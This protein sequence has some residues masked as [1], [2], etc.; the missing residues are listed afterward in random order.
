MW[1]TANIFRAVVLIVVLGIVP[2]CAKDGIVIVK[3]IS[4]TKVENREFKDE[5]LRL[6]VSTK[7][8]CHWTHLI[9]SSSGTIRHIWYRNSRRVDDIPLKIEQGRFRTWSCKENL[10][11][12]QWEVDTLDERGN[13]LSQSV[14]DMLDR[15]KFEDFM[16]SCEAYFYCN[17]LEKS[18]LNRPV[19][20]LDVSPKDRTQTHLG[21]EISTNI[22]EITDQSGNVLWSKPAPV[23]QPWHG[24]CDPLRNGFGAQGYI[25][26]P[27]DH[28]VK[29]VNVKFTIRMIC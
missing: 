19:I 6:P 12:G 26:P 17:N 7:R 4:T 10:G 23:G 15:F 9:S 21:V 18:E 3:T 25:F 2:L 28:K 8:V 5:D 24:R 13:I 11:P 1:K 16:F 29:E 27:I 14:F 20:N 22:T